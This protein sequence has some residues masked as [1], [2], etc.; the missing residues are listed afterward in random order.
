MRRYQVLF[1]AVL[2]DLKRL[3]VAI[4]LNGNGDGL[5]DHPIKDHVY[6]QPEPDIFLFGEFQQRFPDQ[7][8]FGD[9]IQDLSMDKQTMHLAWGDSR[10]GFQGVWY[11]RVQLSAFE[12]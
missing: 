7:I 10:A 6:L 1:L 2:L 4:G 3:L 9:D 5:I 11:G 8:V 12:F